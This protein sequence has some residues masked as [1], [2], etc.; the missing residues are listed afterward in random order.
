MMC[1]SSLFRREIVSGRMSSVRMWLMKRP[2]CI[3]TVVVV[4]SSKKSTEMK[5]KAGCPLGQCRCIYPYSGRA[6]LVPIEI[7]K[8]IHC[9]TFSITFL[10]Q[11]SLADLNDSSNYYY[12]YYFICLRHNGP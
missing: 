6:Q 1:L 9:C 11:S 10:A 8:G 4:I 5:G 7:R 2:R 3:G 12:Y